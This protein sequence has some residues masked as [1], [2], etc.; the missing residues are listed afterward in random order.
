MSGKKTGI[1]NDK[2]RTLVKIA[3]LG[4]LA[5]VVML[6]EIP[7]WFAPSFYQM[8]FSEAVVLIGGF[9]LGPLAAASIEAMKIVLNLLFTGTKTAFVGEI[10]NFLIG[11]ALVMP[12]SLIYRHH[13]SRK[14]A[15]YG[16]L[17]GIL[18]LTVTGALLN[19]FVLLPAY[20][21]FFH[22][23]MSALVAMGTAV[24][25]AID[26]AWKLVLLATVPFNLLKGVIDTAIVLLLY[27]RVS[28]LLH[29]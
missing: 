2:V 4:A 24:N 19:Y 22:M 29:R 10:A 21:Y 28:P 16:M 18:C 23:E 14:N 25:P 27:K 1:R 5:Y 20:A 3:I 6:F 11:C 8:D 26:S 13:K 9:A 7:L 17:A 15:L 12:A